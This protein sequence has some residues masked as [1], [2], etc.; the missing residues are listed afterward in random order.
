MRRGCQI[1]HIGKLPENI[2][3]ESDWNSK[4]ARGRCWFSYKHIYHALNTWFGWAWYSAIG[5]SN[6]WSEGL[7]IQEWLQ[8]TLMLRK[9]PADFEVVHWLWSERCPGRIG[10]L[11]LIWAPNCRPRGINSLQYRAV[12]ISEDEASKLVR[13]RRSSCTMIIR[14]PLLIRNPKR[15]FFRARAI[16]A[17]WRGSTS[18]DK[19]LS[20]LSSTVSLSITSRYQW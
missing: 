11:R 19:F 10:T 17:A 2:V 15:G 14:F 18:L 6:A 13:R 7:Y 5:E 20:L 3:R 8:P 4:W 12:V 1:Q 16:W 9:F